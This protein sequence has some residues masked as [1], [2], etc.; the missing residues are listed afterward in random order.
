[1]GGFTAC[2]ADG[3]YASLAQ[4]DIDQELAADPR[5]QVIGAGQ[6]DLLFDGEEQLER[7]VGE[8]LVA[9]SARQMAMAIP[10]SAPRV[11]RSACSQLRP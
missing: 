5:V 8:R 3:E 10:L 11:V 6:S 7:W 4:I 1:M 9:A 2:A